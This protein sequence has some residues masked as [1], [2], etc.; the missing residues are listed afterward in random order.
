VYDVMTVGMPNAMLGRGGPIVSRLALG[1]MTF[2]VESDE[3]TA[4]G[5]LDLFTASGGTFIDSADAYAAGESERIVGRWIERRGGH[6]DLIVAT[7]GRFAPPACSTGASR[8]GLR[9]AAERSR[10][11]LKVDAIDL[12]SVHGWDKDVPVEATLEALADLVSQGVIHHVGWSNV[13]GWQ[14]QKIIST[15]DARNLPRPV[16]LQP[17]YNLLDRGI[18]PE[19]LPCCLDEGIS[20]TPWSP[21]GGGWLTGKYSG[22]KRPE[23]ATRLGENPARGV[24]AYDVRNTDKT[25]RILQ[26]LREIAAAHDRPLSHIAL[27]WLLQRPGVGSVLLGSRT[28]A[29]LEDNLGAA[30]LTLSM[31]EVAALTTVSA[32][33]L[34]PYPYGLLEDYAGLTVWK[35]LG[36]AWPN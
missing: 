17:Q 5:Q 3:A 19:I 32:P 6:D 23:G 1:T 12:Y 2:G 22:E 18:E 4:H 29:Q 24:E 28:V 11:R 30:G 20:I 7:K 26:V 9:I 15:A 35:E 14:L 10:E 16:A 36:V 34:P 27:A 33:G 13:T 8:R 31:D 25:H 21:L